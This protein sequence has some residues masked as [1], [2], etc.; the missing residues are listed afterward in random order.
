M[1]ALDEGFHVNL[2]MMY[3]YLGIGY[4]TQ[5]FIYS[6]S[7]YSADTGKRSRPYFV[8]S[9]SNHRFPPIRPE[10]KSYVEWIMQLIYLAVCYFWFT[11]CCFLV[12]PKLTPTSNEETL[13]AYLKRIRLPWHFVK[14]YLLPL[15][16]SVTTC[17]HDA[18][19]AFP[20]LDAVNYAKK[21]YRQPHYT[22]IGGVHNVQSKLSKGLDVN[23]RA[24][25][26]SVK[27]TGGRVEVTWVDSNKESFSSYFDHVVMAVTPDVVGTLFEPLRET[28]RVIPVVR[29]E[30]VVHQDTSAI[31]ECSRSLA[32]FSNESP[33]SCNQAQIM[34]ISTDF[35]STESIHQQLPLLV[36]NFPIA[37]IDQ[38]KIVHRVR[39]TRV[40]R[41]PESRGIVN[42]IFSLDQSEL[43][44]LD[45]APSWRNGNGNVWLVGAWCWDGM[46]LLE[47]CVVS[48][49][50][51]AESLGVEVP[52]LVK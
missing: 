21:T 16:S 9:S 36:T 27:S 11:A 52:W 5:K 4:I 10:G 46:V 39:L 45:S 28:M 38:D 20:A 32:K 34:H 33:K 12:K 50:R 25:V 6:L 22:V 24:T 14:T 48:A 51:V 35:S 30:S 40:L 18:L 2:K 26:T 47:G 42:G 29:G 13:Q 7:S 49:M 41:T 17:S 44:A 15:M 8:H 23:F 43:T 31:A 19:L 3:D 1:R 37:P